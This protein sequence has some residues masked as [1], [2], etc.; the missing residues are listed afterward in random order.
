M[1]ENLQILAHAP[2]ARETP[3][4]LFEMMRSFTALARTLNLSQAVEELGSTRQTVKRHIAQLEEA[5]GGKLFEVEQR[6][7]VLSALGERSLESAQTVLDQAKIWY[8][9]A[10][11]HVGGML[12][13]AF[14]SDTG[15]LYYQ[16]QLP[17]SCVWQGESDLLR[18]AI[19]AWSLSEGMLE[20]HHM[21]DV[22]P[23]LLA[24]RENSEGWI[25]TEVGEESFY[26]NWYGWA[27]ARSS[28][29]RNLGSFQGGQAFASLSDRP[30]RDAA[31]TG[32]VRVDQVMVQTAAEGEGA[33]TAIIFDRLMMGVRMP[34]NSP[35]VI[36]V[37]DRA[38]DVKIL[39]VSDDV[40]TQLP[41][42]AKVDFN[43]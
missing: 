17:I 39:G 3:A 11:Q 24:Y 13:F 34:D 25:C 38:Y 9:G 43:L 19:K 1:G 6:R 27:Q 12:R 30:F 2:V 21:S 36:S 20:S 28:V 26:S 16:Q 18:A 5:M 15:S 14:E 7:Y 33:P 22:R 42:R 41:P 10:F 40:L 31:T 32:G 4:L 29:G 35:A 8:D 37:V 23:Y